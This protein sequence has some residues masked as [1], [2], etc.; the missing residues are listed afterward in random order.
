MWRGGGVGVEG[1]GVEVWVW[2][3]GGMGVEGWYM[4]EGE[5]QGIEEKR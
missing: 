1:V 3:C 5:E 2:R 4:W